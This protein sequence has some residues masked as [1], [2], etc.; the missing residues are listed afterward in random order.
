MIKAMNKVKW[1]GTSVSD[2][3]T[4]IG[5]VQQPFERDEI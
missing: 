2:H 4:G 5:K 3:E 1:E